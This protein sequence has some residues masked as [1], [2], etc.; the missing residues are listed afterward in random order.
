MRPPTGTPA[1]RTRTAHRHN[2]RFDLCQ[3]CLRHLQVPAF[4][5]TEW[6]YRR[7][8]ARSCTAL[9][10]AVPPLGLPWGRSARCRCSRPPRSPFALLHRLEALKGYSWAYKTGPHP[11]VIDTKRP[12]IAG[13]AGAGLKSYC[14]LRDQVAGRASQ[15]VPGHLADSSLRH[16]VEPVKAEIDQGSQN[17]S[18]ITSEEDAALGMRP[19]MDVEA[20]STAEVSFGRRPEPDRR[21]RE[22]RMVHDPHVI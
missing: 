15:H 9:S 5:R 1:V 20:A 13:N 3:R 22:T 6:H 14:G 2:L 18:G 8:C 4:P 16:H 7:L 12:A 17:P 10:P 21:R 19:A 11:F